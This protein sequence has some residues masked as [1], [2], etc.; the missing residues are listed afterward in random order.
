M[1]KLLIVSWEGFTWPA[2]W[3][4]QYFTRLAPCLSWADVRP[5]IAHSRWMPL[6]EFYVKW[7]NSFAQQLR[8]SNLWPCVKPVILSQ[9]GYYDKPV[10]KMMRWVLPMQLHV[11]TYHLSGALLG[12]CMQDGNER[13]LPVWPGPEVTFN[14]YINA[15]PVQCRHLVCLKRKVMPVLS[16]WHKASLSHN[17]C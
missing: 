16:L 7:W 14:L 1:R 2:P 8:P 9:V 12:Q 13:M 5:K 17:Y 4:W 10:C 15:P 3:A 6:C 11:K